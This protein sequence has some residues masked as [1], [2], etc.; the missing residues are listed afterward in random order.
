ML[1]GLGPRL[2]TRELSST[3]CQ[4][5]PRP[6]SLKV[7]CFV[8]VKA[9]SCH[10]GDR[11]DTKAHI[12]RS[13]SIPERALERQQA[14]ARSIQEHKCG[15][16]Q[17]LLT[18]A[19]TG[20]CSHLWGAHLVILAPR[21]RTAHSNCNTQQWLLGFSSG[22]LCCWVGWKEQ[23]TCYSHRPRVELGIIWV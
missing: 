22:F 20:L 6:F 15:Q 21:L 7:Y 23:R 4:L 11:Q 1:R 3:V 17:R 5:L 18:W 9:C 13:Y 10:H 14:Q 16:Y 8:F 2:G 19:L 12:L